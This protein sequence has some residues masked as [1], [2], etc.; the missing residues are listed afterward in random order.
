VSSSR[1]AR[2]PVFHARSSRHEPGASSVGLA[3]HGALDESQ[4][5]WSPSSCPPCTYSPPPPAA[6][7]WGVLGK[8]SRGR[9]VGHG[10][11]L[12][13]SAPKPSA[14]ETPKPSPSS[15]LAVATP[16]ATSIPSNASNACSKPTNLEDLDALG[17]IYA[18]RTGLRALWTLWSV[19]VRVL[20]G[21]LGKPRKTGLFAARRHFHTP[22]AVVGIVATRQQT[23]ACPPVRLRRML[24]AHASAELATDSSC[25]K[26]CELYP[27]A[28][29][30]CSVGGAL[31][32]R[33][34]EG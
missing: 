10:R 34:G 15:L 28:D 24:L 27:V 17:S 30:V 33:R 6:E 16:V 26:P 14:L 23:A 3:R 32:V 11:R 1:A 7:A 20:S 12:S 13:G 31:S 18:P 4:K 22:S 8:Y 21:A 29:S 9:R 25:V 19:E 5:L 2:R